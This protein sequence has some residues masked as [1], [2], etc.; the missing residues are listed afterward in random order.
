[1]DSRKALGVN[2]VQPVT[3]DHSLS[4]RGLHRQSLGFLKDARGVDVSAELLAASATSQ[5]SR[6]FEVLT[7]L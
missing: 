7:E 3:S 1:M 6:L 5:M 4:L 2:E